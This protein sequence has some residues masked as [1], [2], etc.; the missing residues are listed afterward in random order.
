MI[1]AQR[2]FLINLWHT[3]ISIHILHTDLHTLPKVLTR[4]I[5]LP[6]KSFLIKLMIISFYSHDFIVWFRSDVVRR[7]QMWITVRGLSKALVMSK[8]IRRFMCSLWPIV[9]T[10]TVTKWRVYLI[11]GNTYWSSG[12]GVCFPFACWSVCWVWLVSLP[13]MKFPTFFLQV[14]KINNTTIN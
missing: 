13:A 5:C 1:T 3:I 4:R 2:L 6:I 12:R 11:P 10:S 7:N 8:S 14:K 9:V